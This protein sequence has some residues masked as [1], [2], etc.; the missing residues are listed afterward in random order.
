MNN[1]EVSFKMDTDVDRR[2]YNGHTVVILEDRTTKMMNP[3]G[4]SRQYIFPD[5]LYIA[6]FSKS[7]LWTY[8]RG[9]GHKFHILTA[10]LPV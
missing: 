7:N 5:L 4:T 10:I 2:T 3:D 8:Y 6:Y 9:S 1:I